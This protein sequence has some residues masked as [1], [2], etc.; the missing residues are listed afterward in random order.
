M[1]SKLNNLIRK[2]RLDLA[3]WIWPKEVKQGDLFTIVR[4][5]RQGIPSTDGSWVGATLRADIVDGDRIGFSELK[6]YFS[7][8][9]F[10]RVGSYWLIPGVNCVVKPIAIPLLPEETRE[11]YA[12]AKQE[13]A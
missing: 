13:S 3:K 10:D 4:N 1:K 11:L 9:R 12:A 7:P 2:L 6:P 5:L 8:T